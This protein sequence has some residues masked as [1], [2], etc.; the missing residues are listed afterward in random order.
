MGKW[1]GGRA[2]RGCVGEIVWWLRQGVRGAGE[3]GVAVR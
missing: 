1:G 3:V 2:G